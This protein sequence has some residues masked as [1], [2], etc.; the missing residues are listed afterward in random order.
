M[1][2]IKDIFSAYAPE[3]LQRFQTSMPHNHLKVIEAIVHCRTQSCG[4]SVYQCEDCGRI[5]RLF[6]S[7]GDRHC[8]TCQNHKVQKWLHRHLTNQLPG[9]HFMITFTVPDKIRPLIR[10][11]QKKC[12]PALFKASSGAL[13]VLAAD[14]KHIG[15]DLPGFFGVL[16][17][18]GRQMQY[19]PHIHY[20]VPGGALDK[21]HQQWIPSRIDFYVPV[22]ALSVIFTAKFRDQMKKGALMDAIHPSLWQDPWNVHIQPV[23][24]GER[25]VRYLA[26]YLFKVAISNSRIIKVMNRKVTFLYKKKKSRRWR[27]ISLDVMEFIRRFLQHVLP[28]G[29]MKVRYYG[30]MNHNASF[31][32]EQVN[33]RIQKAF[34]F[35]ISD[36]EPHIGPTQ[37]TLTCSGCG[38]KMAFRFY[39]G[40]YR[41]TELLDSG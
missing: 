33:M 24:S 7:C 36:S 15:G 9:H 41:K 32:I 12:Y 10:K 38:G 18:W 4:I 2:T 29:F 5:H 13:K 3:Y 16:H 19:H 30:F 27:R 11:N 31:S 34:G 20:I 21:S 1:K 25:S 39:L 8:P 26:P 40:T 22:R 14:P 35:E 23:G 17:T 28:N 6:R 37:P